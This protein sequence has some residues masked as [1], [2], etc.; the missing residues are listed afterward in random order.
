[1]AVARTARTVCAATPQGARGAQGGALIT[2]SYVLGTL[3][4]D[5]T[6][7]LTHADNQRMARGEEVP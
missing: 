6:A 3:F 5:G 1:M 4:A 2:T 7:I